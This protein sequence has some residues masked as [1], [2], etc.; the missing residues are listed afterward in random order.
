[1][2]IAIDGPAGAGK[3]TISD[4]VAR[5]FGIIH[6]DSGA[7]YRALAADLMRQ[8]INIEDEISV[9]A[10]SKKSDIKIVYENGQQH[11]LINGKE[12]K[13]NIRDQD[14]GAAASRISTYPGV[15]SII[16]AVIQSFSSNRDIIMDGRDIATNVIKN[17]ELKIFL[18]AS[19]EQRAR[20]RMTELQNKGITTTFEDVHMSIQQRDAQDMSRKTDPLRCASDAIVIDTTDMSM[21]ESVNAVISLIRERLL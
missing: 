16:V 7:L 20:R 14:I 9:T 6:L 21:E 15:R 13:R 8:G 12:T 17:A 2:K 3:S 19:Q 10:Y 18:T 1:M 5:K 4:E 11:T